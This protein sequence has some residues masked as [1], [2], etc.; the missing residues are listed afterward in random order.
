[1]EAKKEK[2]FFITALLIQEE[3]KRSRE[4]NGKL[5]V[6]LYLMSFDLFLISEIYVHS[7]VVYCLQFYYM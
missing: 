1:M 7:T 4:K 3:N 5:N 6:F 2:I